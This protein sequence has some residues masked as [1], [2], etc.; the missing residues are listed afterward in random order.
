[1]YMIIKPI[2]SRKQTISKFKLPFIIIYKYF[3]LVACF[4]WLWLITLNV[5]ENKNQHSFDWSVL[6]VW[7]I[8]IILTA[9]LFLLCYS[10][11]FFCHHVCICSYWKQHAQSC[12]GL[13]E[14][15]LA[16][17]INIRGYSAESKDPVCLWCVPL[18]CF[19]ALGTLTCRNGTMLLSLFV[20]L[21]VH[22]K[23]R[24]LC[25]WGCVF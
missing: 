20:C 12:K 2:M 3:S 11:I 23:S 21:A 22:S 19:D 1:M 15:C 8:L 10:K 7:Q 14:A 9:F 25:I 18:S 16:L 5:H 17:D 24:L 4:E 13:N 6:Y